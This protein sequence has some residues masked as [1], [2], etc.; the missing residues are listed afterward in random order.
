MGNMRL[1]RNFRC[2]KLKI[3]SKKAL[4]F[5]RKR[6][7]NKTEEFDRKERIDSK[8]TV[9]AAS[10]V[11]GWCFWSITSLARSSANTS[12]TAGQALPELPKESRNRKSS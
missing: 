11:I 9:G 5:C 1:M 7:K 8:F 10:V 6:R 12:E 3:L 2:R 4:Y